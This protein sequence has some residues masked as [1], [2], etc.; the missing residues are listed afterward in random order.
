MGKSP[1]VKNLGPPWNTFPFPTSPP[2]VKQKPLQDTL[3]SLRAD[4]VMSCSEGNTR[5]TLTKTSGGV[6]FI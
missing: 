6:T 5:F 3:V 2:A 4:K 1:G